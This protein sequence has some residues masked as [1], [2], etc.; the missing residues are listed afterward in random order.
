MFIFSKKQTLRGKKLEVSGESHLSGGISHTSVGHAQ[1]HAKHAPGT[2]TLTHAAE[3]IIMFGR[4]CARQQGK[5][6]SR[7]IKIPTTDKSPPQRAPLT[8]CFVELL[9]KPFVAYPS[10]VTTSL[11]PPLLH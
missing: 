2:R 10:E 5:Q 11:Q 4:G 8:S 1:T 9:W 3:Q 6:I 7:R